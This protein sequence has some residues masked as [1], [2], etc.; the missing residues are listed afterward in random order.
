MS[1][2]S[3]IYEVSLLLTSELISSSATVANLVLAAPINCYTVT[4]ALELL[5]EARTVPHY[6]RHNLVAHV[7]PK[8][9]HNATVDQR[10]ILSLALP[11]GDA[12][13]LA[14]GSVP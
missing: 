11:R 5:S 3:L 6:E 9:V 13:T 8:L 12:H 10:V 4:Q 1:S 7:H 14:L 2:I